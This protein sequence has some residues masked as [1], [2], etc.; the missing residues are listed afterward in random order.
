MLPEVT[1]KPRRALPFFGRHP[2]VFAGAIRSLCG[3]PETG[4]EVLLRSSQGKFIARGLYNPESNIRV[5]LY[6]W[7]EAVPIDA[8]FLS[9][10]LDAALELR[11]SFVPRTS[12]NSAR[13]LVFSESDGISGLI[14]DQ[15]EDHLLLQLTSAA[16]QRHL[17]AIVAT[18]RDKLNPAGIWLRTEKGIRESEGLDLRD[19]LIDGV[20]PP[21][22]LFI[23]ENGIRYGV[24]VSEGQKTGFFIDQRENRAAVAKFVRN[25]RVL[26]M[27]CYSG[28]FGL[29]AVVNGGARSVRAVDVSEAALTLARANAELNE[30]SEKFQFEKS[31]AYQALERLAE[32]GEQFDTVILDPPKMARHRKGLDRALRGYYSLNQL[33]LRVLAPGGLLVTCS[34]SG[35]VDRPLFEGMLAKVATDCNRPLQVLEARGAGPD[36]PISVHCTENNYLKCFLCRVG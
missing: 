26:D 35:H 20:E 29:N 8:V 22:P 16:L 21:R 9:K 34:C 28:G 17:D 15:Y 4:D 7:D 33:A 11:E 1:L 27:F 18:L 19:G 25:H 14:V 23:V 36:H 30:V 12:D 6:S 3:K 10:R 32:A 31:D 13:R 2:W 24:D 5:R